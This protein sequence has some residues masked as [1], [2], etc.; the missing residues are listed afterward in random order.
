[1]SYV[2]QLP[3]SP[4]ARW[5]PRLIGGYADDAIP[6]DVLKRSLTSRPTS[7]ADPQQDVWKEM[8]AAAASRTTGKTYSGA[9]MN[10][11]RGA[12]A[13]AIARLVE[14]DESRVTILAPTIAKLS[15]RPNRS[16]QKRGAAEAVYATYAL[17]PR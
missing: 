11:V 5:L 14:V 3:E 12:A 1:M 7:H 10:S 6:N 16:R 9:G 17:A 13:E 8:T 15:E 2:A 4:G